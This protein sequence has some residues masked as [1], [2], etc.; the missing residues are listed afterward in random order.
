M[1][2]EAVCQLWQRLRYE[3][4]IRGIGLLSPIS[5]YDCRCSRR[6]L[7]RITTIDRDETSGGY[8][9]DHG[10]P[11]SSEFTLCEIH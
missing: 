10:H 7:C 11:T 2:A 6:Y 1:L 4:F 9:V 5:R 3:M 8:T